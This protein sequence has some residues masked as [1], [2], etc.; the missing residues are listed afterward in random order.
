MKY[1]ITREMRFVFLCSAMPMPEVYLKRAERLYSEGLD[2][3]ECVKIAY[4][5]QVYGLF[6]SNLKKYFPAAGQATRSGEASGITD[7]IRGLYENA[8]KNKIAA[9]KQSGEL[10]RLVRLMEGAGIR[11]VPMKG[12][13]LSKILYGEATYRVA[14]DIDILVP[15]EKLAEAKELLLSHGY[16]CLKDYVETEKQTEVYESKFH[17][18]DFE[19][20]NGVRLELHWRVAD[21]KNAEILSIDDAQSELEFYGQILPSFCAEELLVY[22]AYHGV[23]H[24]YMWMKW[25]VD[26]DALSHHPLID[27]EKVKKIAAMRKMTFALEASESLAALVA[28]EN[29][30]RTVFGTQLTKEML[31]V[32]T[33]SGGVKDD[34]FKAYRLYLDGEMDRRGLVTKKEKKRRIDPS[35]KD[36]ERFHFS[37]RFFFL[38]YI[39]RG[40]Y[41][42]YRKLFKKDESER[43]AKGRKKADR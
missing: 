38:Y 7:E 23:H 40:P 26:F 6:A 13:I 8:N 41:K 22:L 14:T 15:H 37:D 12:V 2:L 1:G 42:L 30:T 28:G 5:H 21:Y 31:K 9:M 20:E 35:E 3:S 39:V 11:A 18:Y 27:R 4:V 24:G 10:V 32:L 29:E 34:T 16:K 25:L 17:D 36:F 33:G 43:K 19:S